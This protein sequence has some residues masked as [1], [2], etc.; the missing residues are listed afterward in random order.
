[1]VRVRKCKIIP[2]GAN[3]FRNSS[4][5]T[6]LIED[7]ANAVADAAD[8]ETPKPGAATVNPNY[9]VKVSNGPQRA[10]AAVIAANGIS[11]RHNAGHNTLVKSLDAAR[12]KQ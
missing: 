4:E 9:V 2:A 3:S 8:A 10:S 7:L 12:G 11:M 5:V 1:M 6:E